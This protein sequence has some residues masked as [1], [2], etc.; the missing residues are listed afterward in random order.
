MGFSDINK[1]MVIHQLVHQLRVDLM[2]NAFLADDESRGGLVNVELIL[3]EPIKS[4]D[5]V[6]TLIFRNWGA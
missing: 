2:I 4:K 5:N 1:T 3:L 6:K